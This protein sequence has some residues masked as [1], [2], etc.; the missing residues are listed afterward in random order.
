MGQNSQ[1]FQKFLDTNQY[2]WKGV[3]LYEEIFGKTWVSTGGEETTERFIRDHLREDL[4]KVQ[5]GARVL[6]IGCGSGGSA[7]YMARRFG[8]HFLGVDLSSNMIELAKVYRAK[9]EPAVQHRCQFRVEDATTMPYPENFYDVLYSRDT[10]LHIEDKKSLFEDFYKTLKP[11]GLLFIT[12]YCHGEPAGHTQRFKDYVKQRGYI[13]KTVPEY[14]KILE[15]AGFTEVEAIDGTDYFVEILNTELARFV[16]QKAMIEKE[17]S[18]SDYNK[19]VD[20]WNDKL[21]RCADGD[22][23]WGIFV[24]RKPYTE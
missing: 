6:D 1:E 9:Q 24:A 4:I 23:K 2:S 7:F 17:Y 15:S 22:Q 21:V 8:A 3:T 10:I 5:G 13:L 19:I 12:D 14:G 11:G 18:L 20:G 16:P